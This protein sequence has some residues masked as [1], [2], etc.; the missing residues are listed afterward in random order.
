MKARKGDKATG[1]GCG[2]GGRLRSFRLDSRN[3]VPEQPQSLMLGGWV[4]GRRCCAPGMKDMRR[5]NRKY[6]VRANS[7]YL[8][9]PYRSLI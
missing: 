1:L 2:G 7:S 4:T 5:R 8:P 9:E 6:E 3:P